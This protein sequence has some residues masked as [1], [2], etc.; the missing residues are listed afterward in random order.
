MSLLL[1]EDNTISLRM[2]EVVLQS[3]GFVVITAKTGKQALERLRENDDIQLVLTDLMMPEM[4]GMQL[5]EEINK[6]PRWK[7]LPVIVLT[8]LSDADTVRRVVQLGCRNYLVKPLKEDV[9][10]PKVKALLAEAGSASRDS[11]LRSKFK[12]LQ[13]GG[14][15]P[16]QYD[17][18]FDVF[19]TQVKEVVPA[20]AEVKAL[21]SNE[22]LGRQVLALRD[23]AAVLCQG[24]FPALLDGFKSRG[25]CDV[26]LLRQVLSD[27]LSAMDAAAGLRARVK[28]KVGRSEPPPE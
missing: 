10:I 4:D 25:S 28:E 18:L 8:S 23:G 27:I 13:E 26:P 7:S 16:E 14:V 5:L 24:R 3:N 15:D 1:V 11:G 6:H 17:R 22:P 12:V 9:V 19:H 20:L 2:L 21:T